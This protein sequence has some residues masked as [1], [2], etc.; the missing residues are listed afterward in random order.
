MPIR[1]SLEQTGLD[2]LDPSSAV[3]VQFVSRLAQESL[4]QGTSRLAHRG[5]RQLWPHRQLLTVQGTC[6]CT[7][8]CLRKKPGSQLGGRNSKGTRATLCSSASS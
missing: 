4:V 1:S 8:T 7:C 6:T 2:H 3:V 5:S